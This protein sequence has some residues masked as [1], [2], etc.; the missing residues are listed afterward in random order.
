MEGVESWGGRFPVNDIINLLDH[1]PTHNLGEST[2]QDLVF[3]ELLDVI[4]MDAVR[5]LRLGYGSAVGSAPLRDR[6]A[7][8]SGVPAEHVVTTQGVGLALFLL[9]F[10]QCRASDEAVITT[11]CFPP[12]RDALTG[13]GVTV[14]PVRLDFDDGYRLDVEE[15]VHHL[16][17]DVGGPRSDRTSPNRRLPPFRL[18]TRGC[19][20]A[21]VV[22]R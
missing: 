13:A 9:A 19:R 2:S 6:I 7:D 18:D 4:G 3:G 5:D 21:R 14:I 10:E 15:I 20:P 22:R 1:F 8:I 11:P 12:S 17:P 16:G